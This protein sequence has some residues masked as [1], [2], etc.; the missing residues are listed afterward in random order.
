[1]NESPPM[2]GFFLFEC[3]ANLF[4]KALELK[5][6]FAKQIV[7]FI[8]TLGKERSIKLI[9]PDPQKRLMERLA[10]LFMVVISIPE[11]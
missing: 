10:F 8:L 11:S 2:A 9:S 1:M 5:D 7:V 4:A 3:V 6:R